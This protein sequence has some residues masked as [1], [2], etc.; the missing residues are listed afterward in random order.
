MRNAGDIDLG[1]AARRLWACSWA[2]RPEDLRSWAGQDWIQSLS[3]LVDRAGE[4]FLAT[5]P[6]GWHRAWCAP[7]PIADVAVA[8]RA[9][10]QSLDGFEAESWLDGLAAAASRRSD[11][12]SRR[13]GSWEAACERWARYR[14]RLQARAWVRELVSPIALPPRGLHPYVDFLGKHDNAPARSVLA[15]WPYSQNC[16]LGAIR[17]SK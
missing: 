7:D 12:P 1:S 4:A 6:P 11:L 13:G 10:L 5:V 15:N 8:R 14:A 9:V 3:R 16:F 2:N 17:A